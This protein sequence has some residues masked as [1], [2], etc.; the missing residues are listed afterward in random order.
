MK[1]PEEQWYE[2]AKTNNE[3]LGFNDDHERKIWTAAF[4]RY[5]EKRIVDLDSAE[6]FADMAVLR[7]RKR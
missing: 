6:R 7:Y 4:N 5:L 2:F 1:T 3:I